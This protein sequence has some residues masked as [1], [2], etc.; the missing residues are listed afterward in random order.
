[1]TKP[2][3]R[4]NWTRDEL[5][6]VGCVVLLAVGAMAFVYLTTNDLRWV[7]VLVVV[8]VIAG[9]IGGM[10][11]APVMP[12]DDRNRAQGAI[13]AKPA[14]MTEPSQAGGGELAHEA[15]AT[16]SRPWRSAFESVELDDG[17]TIRPAL[18]VRFP[19]ARL[20]I[21]S[22]VIV[23]LT[24][25]TSAFLFIRSPPADRAAVEVAL[26]SIGVVFGVWVVQMLAVAARGGFFGLTEAG[27]VVATGLTRLSVPWAA[28]G[29]A[30]ADLLDARSGYPVLSLL[31]K[32]PSS[33]PGWPWTTTFVVMLFGSSRRDL[34]ILA[35]WFQPV[36]LDPVIET[37]RH[38]IR[39][40]EDRKRIGVAH[41]E[42]WLVEKRE[43]GWFDQP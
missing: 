32:P 29:T 18:L 6:A 16:V 9:A 3:R 31:L 38:L 42:T 5:L 12:A 11:G 15:E 10:S 25:A 1:V 41:P 35:W 7:G 40:P 21:V 34:R 22:L 30:R 2:T 28:I 13:P 39:H 17:G 14:S 20:G 23:V 43:S 33:V 26:I 27:V 4:W 19:R 8:M 36:P 37:I 24:A